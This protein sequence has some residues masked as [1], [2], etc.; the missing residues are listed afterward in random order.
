MLKWGI[1]MIANSSTFHPHRKGSQGS[2]LS[3]A[4]FN[5]ALTLMLAVIAL[6]HP[7]I[8]C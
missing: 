1:G 8:E 6:K 7:A 2:V 5:T 4:C 3:V